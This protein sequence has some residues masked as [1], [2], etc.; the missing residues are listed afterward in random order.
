MQDVIHDIQIIE[1]DVKDVEEKCEKINCMAV[2]EGDCTKNCRN[3]G[4]SQKRFPTFLGNRPLFLGNIPLPKGNFPDFWE[5]F[6]EIWEIVQIF[7][8]VSGRLFYFRI[9]RDYRSEHRAHAA[10]RRDRWNTRAG[11]HC[12]SL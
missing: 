10:D 2:Y 5:N 9:N 6:P 1:E 11:V 7:A 3:F 8:T 12:T 4:K